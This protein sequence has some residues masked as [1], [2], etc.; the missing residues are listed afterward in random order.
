MITFEQFF[1]AATG[2]P[3]YDYQQRLA[4]G[5]VGRSC[6][7]QLINV[8][9]G[10]GKTAAVVLAWLWNRPFRSL[11]SQLSTINQT[12]PRRLVYCLPMRMLGGGGL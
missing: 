6:E 1:K 7:S 9:T 12:W 5:G 11:N 3:P 2:H 8:P 4:G 10:L